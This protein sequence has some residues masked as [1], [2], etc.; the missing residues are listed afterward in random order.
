MKNTI[1][2]MMLSMAFIIIPSFDSNAAIGDYFT[3]GDFTYLVNNDNQTVTLAFAPY[4]SGQVVI[5]ETVEYNGI[6]YTVTIIG[7]GAFFENEGIITDVTIPNT[8]TT[9]GNCAFSQC[10]GLKSIVIPNSVTI[11]GELAFHG[12]KGAESITLGN[13][14]K[15]IGDMAFS[16]CSKVTSLTIPQSVTYIGYSAFSTCY[17]LDAIYITDLAKWCQIDFFDSNPLVYAK[18]LY[19]N[20]EE[21]TDLVI[22]ENIRTIKPYAFNGYKGLKSVTIPASTTS[23]GWHA[24]S[25]CRNLESSIIDEK[26]PKYDSRENC[27]AIIDKETNSLFMG[28]KNSIVPN[29]VT[30]IGAGA[31]SNCYGLTEISLPNSVSRIEESAFY[32]C[33]NL[34][35]VTIPKTMSYIGTWAFTSCTSL[36]NIYCYAFNP[37]NGE[38]ESFM[39]VNEVSCVLHVPKG[40][41]QAYKKS[42]VWIRF[43]N[44]IVDDID[45]HLEPG[46]VN[47]DEHVNVTDVTSLVNM[48]LGV[49]IKNDYTADVNGDGKVNV[50][51]VTALINRILGIK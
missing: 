39:G 1:I 41:T 48:I 42:Y 46:D 5:P 18:H 36:D 26:N 4:V 10:E 22:P 8:V 16:G 25:M 38:F 6:N 15:S 17:A 34:K 47:G 30:S 32:D 31:F 49:T 21:I 33:L 20:G 28:C 45:L 2:T 13:S 11:I 51:D 35:D 27:N 19:L 29:S 23:I 7:E 24:F 40:Q 50:S 14:V 44:N 12:C 37:P 9:I 43:Q 3:V